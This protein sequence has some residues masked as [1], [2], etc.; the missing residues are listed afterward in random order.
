[1]NAKAADDWLVVFP[2]QALPLLLKWR[3]MS[4]EPLD[5]PASLPDR[6]EVLRAR[7]LGMFVVIG[8]VQATV[9]LLSLG[10]M[11][12]MKVV[13]PQAKQSMM[14]EAHKEGGEQ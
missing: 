13:V 3:R 14:N 12:L 10:F 4:P 9:L 8:C 1:V 6:A 5:V 2:C 11:L 7:R